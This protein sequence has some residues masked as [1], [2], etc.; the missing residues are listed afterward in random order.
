MYNYG[1]VKRV[2]PRMTV[3]RGFDPNQPK[4]GTRAFRVAS[5]VTILSGQLISAVWNADDSVYE[6]VLGLDASANVAYWALQDSADYDVV[7]AGSL[8]GYSCLGDFELQT[9]YF[10]TGQS[11]PADTFLTPGTAGNVGSV[12]PTTLESGVP[13]VGIVTRNHA[14]VDLGDKGA[15][16]YP[17]DSSSTSQEVITLATK[18]LPNSGDAT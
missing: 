10:V 4:N 6:W 13:I 5:G 1:T 7:S 18:Y 14:P 2:K 16:G 15:S 11:Y 3:L 12:T 17:S 9:G 8:V